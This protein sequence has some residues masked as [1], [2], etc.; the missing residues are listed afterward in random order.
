MASYAGAQYIGRDSFLIFSVGS[1]WAFS[2][3]SIA[4]GRKWTSSVVVTCFH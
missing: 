3:L 4:L 2:S 1:L